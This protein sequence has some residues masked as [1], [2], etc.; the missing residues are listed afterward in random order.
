MDFYGNKEDIIPT[1]NIEESIQS[2]NFIDENLNKIQDQIKSA[3]VFKSKYVKISNVS[4]FYSQFNISELVKSFEK[5]GLKI[6]I[7]KSLM[8]DDEMKNSVDQLRKRLCLSLNT[9]F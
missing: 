6:K 8:L 4:M 5:D 1:V 2:F 3:K 9:A 7:N